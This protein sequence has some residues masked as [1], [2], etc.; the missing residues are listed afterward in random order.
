[1][2]TNQA[3]EIKKLY[4]YLHEI[5]Q[6]K[7]I[8]DYSHPVDRVMGK[9][10]E[11]WIPKSVAAASLFRS[12]GGSCGA[13]IGHLIRLRGKRRGRC[14][15]RVGLLSVVIA[16]SPFSTRLHLLTNIQA[17]LFSQ[18]ILGG[19][20]TGINDFN[21][22]VINGIHNLYSLEPRPRLWF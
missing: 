18:Q 13:D 4:F 6:L 1:M 20:S 7:I 15:A 12:N 2:W 11:D 21:K 3:L 14:G 16:G 5:L 22:H 10:F 9:E 8:I 19:Y 17:G